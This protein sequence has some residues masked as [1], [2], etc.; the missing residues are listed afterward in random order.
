MQAT[1][2]IKVS[3]SWKNS[4]GLNFRHKKVRYTI[5]DAELP[6]DL[7]KTIKNTPIACE[8]VF[9]WL[10][11]CGHTKN[12]TNWFCWIN[13]SQRNVVTWNFK[14]LCNRI[15]IK[16]LFNNKIQNNLIWGNRCKCN[17]FLNFS[18][19][20]FCASWNFWNHDIILK[21][22]LYGTEHLILTPL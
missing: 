19:Y 7:K 9:F 18:P 22:E 2:S 8:R 15:I 4:S 21:F 10:R 6:V 20:F 13:P 17:T 14:M 1:G 5:S 12:H 16:G 3:F 11:I